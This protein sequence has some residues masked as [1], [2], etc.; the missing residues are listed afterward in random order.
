MAFF[1]NSLWR[2]LTITA[3][4]MFGLEHITLLNDLFGIAGFVRSLLA[5]NLFSPLNITVGLILGIIA[6][7][8]FSDMTGMFRRGVGVY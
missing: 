8:G 4:L 7:K 1:K 5:L 6:L 2:G 3:L